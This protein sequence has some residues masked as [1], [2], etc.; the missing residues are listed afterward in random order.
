W[1]DSKLFSSYYDLILE[2]QT[3]KLY[4]IKDSVARTFFLEKGIDVSK[5]P[6]LT[7]VKNWNP[8]TFYEDTNAQTLW[9][10]EI[11][12]L[13]LVPAASQ[14]QETEIVPEKHSLYI[15]HS[16]V[17]GETLWSI[18]EMFYGDPTLW[19]K[20]LEKNVISNVYTLHPGTVL[21]LYYE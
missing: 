15:E 19:E 1:S 8:D 12:F 13:P 4:K 14:T 9:A 5:V 18:S 16:V 17:Q 6:S 21:R 2:N 7:P 10:R 3:S 20:I 11:E